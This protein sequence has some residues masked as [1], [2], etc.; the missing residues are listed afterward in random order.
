MEMK[1]LMFPSALFRF[2]PTTGIMST[3]ASTL[4]RYMLKHH[5]P[6]W[7]DYLLHTMP[8]GT[9]KNGIYVKSAKTGDVEFF[10]L[11]TYVYSRG[12]DRFDKVRNDLGSVIYSKYISEKFPELTVLIENDEYSECA[13]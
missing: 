13:A 12:E 9:S 4:E 1:T 3:T 8:D 7:L 6:T 5:T 11:R 2:N 10:E